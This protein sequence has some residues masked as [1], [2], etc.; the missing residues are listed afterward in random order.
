MLELGK[1][2][3]TGAQIDGMRVVSGFELKRFG[4]FLMEANADGWDGSFYGSDDTVLANCQLRGRSLKCG[5][6][7]AQ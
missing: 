3:L 5:P 7:Q 6:V 1:T 2:P 4:Y